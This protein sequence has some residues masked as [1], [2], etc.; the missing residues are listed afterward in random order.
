VQL[1]PAGGGTIVTLEA[2]DLEADRRRAIIS[3]R[4][5]HHAG[6]E[7]NLV[8]AECVQSRKPLARADT[9][10]LLIMMVVWRADGIFTRFAE[11][12]VWDGG[13]T[14]A[15]LQLPPGSKIGALP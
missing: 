3:P 4:D 14:A 15:N 13:I 1:R 2:L 9:D 12:D 7:I 10:A 8:A 5:V 6:F 11:K